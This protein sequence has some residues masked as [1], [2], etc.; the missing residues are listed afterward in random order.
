MISTPLCFKKTNTCKGMLPTTATRLNN[1][2]NKNNELWS[3]SG[4]GVQSEIAHLPPPCIWQ[5]YG[6]RH[7]FPS[8]TAYDTHASTNSLGLPQFGRA[9]LS[10][11]APL[12]CVRFCGQPWLECVVVWLR[13]SRQRLISSPCNVRWSVPGGGSSDTQ[14]IRPSYKITTPGLTCV[15]SQSFFFFETR[16]ASPYYV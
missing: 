11:S 15:L 2:N 1:N 14:V 4:S 12:Q 10:I 9:S 6:K 3:V 7:T 5:R 13:A 16:R 8:P